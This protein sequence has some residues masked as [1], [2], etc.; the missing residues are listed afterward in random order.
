MKVLR[1]KL[2]FCHS[3][4][5]QSRKVLG[6]SNEVQVESTLVKKYFVTL[7]STQKSNEVLVL[8][9]RFFGHV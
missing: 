9:S 1:S 8:P 3:T 5:L 6:K 2:L 4:S 7:Q